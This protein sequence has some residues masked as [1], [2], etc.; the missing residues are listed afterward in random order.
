M[1]KCCRQM[2]PVIL[3]YKGAAKC[4]L[5]FLL[6]LQFYLMSDILCFSADMN[7]LWSL[8]VV[9]DASRVIFVVVFLLVVVN[10]L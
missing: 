2:S 4:T 3:P 10:L 9:P 8:L 1:R 5:D 6:D 7:P